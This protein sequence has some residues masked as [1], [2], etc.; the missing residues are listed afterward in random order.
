MRRVPA[1]TARPPGLPY[2]LSAR[3]EGRAMARMMLL[4][5]AAAL[6]A[7]PSSAFDRPKKEPDA[8]VRNCPEVGEGYIRVAGSSTCVKVGGL[9]RIEGAAIGGRR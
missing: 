7:S 2:G 5:A 3:R 4:C 6:G 8:K 9:V 1:A